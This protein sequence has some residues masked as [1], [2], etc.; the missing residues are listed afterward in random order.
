MALLYSE[1]A[2]EQAFMLTLR[3]SKQKGINRPLKKDVFYKNALVSY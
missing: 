2:E 3:S 1:A